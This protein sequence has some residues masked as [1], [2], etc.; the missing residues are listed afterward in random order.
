MGKDEPEDELKTFAGQ[1]SLNKTWLDPT[2]AAL[3]QIANYQILQ[4][5]GQGAMGEVYQAEQREPVRRQV[6]LKVI[7]AGMDSAQVVARFESERQALAL[8][9]HPNIARVFDAGVTDS[10]RPY[11]AMEY[12]KGVPVSDYCHRND[13]DVPRRLVLFMQICDG[14]QHAH[15]KGVIHRDIKPSNVLVRIQDD[16][17]VPVIIDFGLAKATAQPL[18]DRPMHTELGQVIGTPEYMSPEQAEMSGL[19]V[20][21][22]TDVYSLGALLYELLAGELPFESKTLRSRSID[23]IRKVIREDDPVRPSERA[24][25]RGPGF[26]ALSR[27]LAGDLDW[28]T[29]KALEKDRTRR[30]ASPNELAQDI[31]R[32]LNDHPVVAG[33][34]SRAYRM[35]KFLKRH[36]VGVAAGGVVL[37]AL[38]LGLLGTA[39]GLVRAQQAEARERQKAATAERVTALLVRLFEVSDPGEARGNTITAREILDRAADRLTGDLNEQPEVRAA[40][41]AS[42]GRVYQS[43][44]L[45]DQ[46]KPLLDDA[47]ATRRRLLGP[48][49][50]DTLTSITAL[51]DHYYNVGQLEEAESHY[52]EALERSRRALGDEHPATLLAINNVGKLLQAQGRLEEAERLT[53]EALEVRLRVR[54]RDH[55]E[56]LVSLND[57]GAVLQDLGRLDEA[58]VYYRD[59]LE[60]HRRAH[61]DDH[62]ET[63][64]ALS[65]LGFLYQAKGELEKAEPY[66]RKALEGQRRVLGND[67]PSTL[68][69]VSNLGYLMQLQGRLDEAERFM[70]EAIES[71]RRV[72]GNDHGTTL[73]AVNNLG[74]LLQSEGK[75]AEAEPLYREAMEGY[76]RTLTDSHALTLNSTANLGDLYTTLGRYDEAER[77]LAAAAAAAPVELTR[78]NVTTGLILRK[79]GRCLTARGRHAEAETALLDAHAVLEEVVGAQHEQT[80]KVVHNLVEL[81]D[82]WKRPE[83]AAAWRARLP[84]GSDAAAD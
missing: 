41:M 42:V 3:P 10:G 14:V 48:E 67:H 27:E 18:S 46:A 12:V 69:S 19:D 77:L 76:S 40:L 47:L 59:A 31:A 61:G 73:T 62:P 7:K 63:L 66:T 20:D 75:L 74:F 38:F 79:Y 5:V 78:D 45:H 83:Q 55:E 33:P 49:H 56:T 28:I 11:F 16:K 29:M 64:V 37:L 50:P 6:A 22:R 9:N 60:G 1:L 81:Y 65:N 21:T 15:Q 34:P 23:E 13:L 57:M 26:L 58:E 25:A 54:G 44:G 4:L 36:K 51:G 8:M 80:V 71:A 84:A 2:P 35:G 53:R 52:R 17:P 82:S 24:R 43:L 30:Y 68:K 32:H 72:L 39:F 70:R